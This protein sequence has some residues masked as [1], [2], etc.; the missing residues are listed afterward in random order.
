VAAAAEVT[1]QFA[2]C[3]ATA[4]RHVAQRLTE[5]AEEVAETIVAENGQPL[6]SA[7]VEVRRAA[8]S[9]RSAAEQATVGAGWRPVVDQS[10]SASG[11]LTVSRRVSRGP[12]LSISPFTFPLEHV[13]RNVAA[14]LAVGA[15]ILIKPSPRAP[16]SALLLAELLAETDLPP[17][18]FSVLPVDDEATLRLVG[19]A[20]LRTVW[21]IGSARTGTL[22]ADA[23][24]RKRL[25][26]E[27]GGEGAAVVWE[28]YAS[29]GDLDFAAAQIATQLGPQAGQQ[30]FSVRQVFLH[31]AVADRFTPR[32]V[33]AVEALRTGD[34]Y[35]E[36]VDLGPMADE[37]TAQEFADW[38]AGAHAAGAQLFTGGGRN[39]AVV[40]PVVLAG[41]P[42]P[43]V[44]GPVPAG[45][46]LCVS[47]VDSVDGLREQ[48]NGS[49]SPLRIGL[50]S[51][52]L[53]LAMRVAAELDAGELIAGG[54]PDHRGR[55][56]VQAM[57]E[58]SEQRL[59]TLRTA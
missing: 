3:A 8:A 39:G 26:L 15:P 46:A 35:D 18:A 40:A 12:A 34:P 28:D 48:L 38:V 4:L 2:D 5:R 52:D 30:C 25:V 1:W 55:T 13:A 27:T 50:F 58:L 54:L 29:D 31:R 23:G 22:I 24:T 17:G 56:L 37:T 20:R 41:I 11:L 7:L 36:H 42:S 9:L 6:K 53:Q 45:P 43:A 44:R 47:T 33:A 57:E 21:F 32:L 19:D 10:Q 14:A 49:A 59:V 16:L 51:R